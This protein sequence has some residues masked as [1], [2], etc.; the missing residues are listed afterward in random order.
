MIRERN[1][2]T[3]EALIE[4]AASPWY[5]LYASRDRG[6]FINMVSIDP[7]AFD[8]LCTV[9]SRHYIVLSGPG[10]RGRP[11]RLVHKHA[12][13][14]CL[15]HFY[16]AEIRAKSL[17]AL[18]GIPPA[19]LSRVLSN[20]EQAL[21]KSLREISDARIRWPSF[22]EQQHWAE[23]CQAKEPLIRG[24]FG[25]ADGL[26]LPVQE[27]TNSDIQN[28]LYNGWLHCTW[29]TGVLCYGFDGCLIWGKHNH[30]G[31]WND[32]EMSRPLQEKLLDPIKTIPN[33]CIATDS[34]FPVSKVLS[35]RIIT[36][37]KDGDLE[38]ASAECRVAMIAMSNA[39]TAIRQAGEWG[40]GSAPKVYRQL[41]LPL[42]FD[43]RVRDLRL[44]NIYRLYNFRVRRT[45]ISQ[46]RNVHN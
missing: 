31:S 39:I 6:S 27:P 43:P 29:V 45:G 9:F 11:S 10:K 40:M 19:T 17:C 32:A 4:P 30:P 1:Y 46:I 24:C 13:L 35:G 5:S 36:P 12:V 22:A 15:L 28:A 8:F 20:A 16:S 44:S 23:L 25:V 21:S 14:A 33:G 7:E 38:R 37:L 26:N 41:N 34:A 18:F 2:L 42:P 3:S